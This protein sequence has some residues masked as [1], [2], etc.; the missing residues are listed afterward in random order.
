MLSQLLRIEMKPELRRALESELERLSTRV[1]AIK[2]LLESSESVPAASLG[3]GKTFSEE[4]RTDGRSLRW[5][6]AGPEQR[7]WWVAAIRAGR[8]RKG[9]KE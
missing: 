1:E 3:K 7:K 8:K 5:Q 6:K 2:L 9:Q 4:G